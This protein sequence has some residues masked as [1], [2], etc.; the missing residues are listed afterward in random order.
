MGCIQT[1]GTTPSP[2]RTLAKLKLESGYV[3][4]ENA[5]KPAKDFYKSFRGGGGGA[6]NADNSGG[7][8]ENKI[9]RESESGVNG[10]GNVS[11]R[12]SVKKI[13]ADELV[14]GWPKWLVENVQ[15]DALAGLVPKSA[16]S[17]DKLAKVS[18]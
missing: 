11:Q 14:D 10:G 9:S 15:G 13:G 12:I 7:T 1:K 17:Y 5:G 6:K 8:G 2:Q 16:D 3:K 18:N 4:R